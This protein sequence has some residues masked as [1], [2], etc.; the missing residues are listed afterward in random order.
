MKQE[1][2]VIDESTIGVPNDESTIGVSN[3]EQHN[4]SV[5]SSN[6]K[7]A[8]CVVISNCLIYDRIP[9]I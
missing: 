3:D 8:V 1:F 7:S 9:D 6:C 4:L 5:N 2:D